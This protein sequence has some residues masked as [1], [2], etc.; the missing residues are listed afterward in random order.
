MLRDRKLLVSIAKNCEKRAMS[1]IAP[2]CSMGRTSSSYASRKGCIHPTLTVSSSSEY[3]SSKDRRFCTTAAVH[4]LSDESEFHEIADETL[5]ELIDSLSKLEDAFD[6]L[7]VDLSVSHHY[8][9]TDLMAFTEL[10]PYVLFI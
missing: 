10:N 7:E 2:V 5:E 1:S 4:V 3:K 8:P 6:D 9:I